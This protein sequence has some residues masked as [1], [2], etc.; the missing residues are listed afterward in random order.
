MTTKTPTTK[1]LLPN[2]RTKTSDASMPAVAASACLFARLLVRFLNCS[3]Q[4]LMFVGCY[5]VPALFSTRMCA[6]GIRNQH[7]PVNS[8]DDDTDSSN[9][10]NN[11]NAD[12][13]DKDA[14]HNNAATS[15]AVTTN[16]NDDD[17]ISNSKRN[18]YKNNKK[19]KQEQ[20]K[21]EEQ[22]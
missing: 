9:N 18:N 4:S 21:Q 8:S 5:F 6:G 17:D 15:T 19:H 11:E 20:Q 10:S 13:D 14:N 22:R 7:Q 2:I 16:N 12:H 1:E 3:L